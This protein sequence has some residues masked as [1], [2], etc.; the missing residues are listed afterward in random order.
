MKNISDHDH[1]MHRG[2]HENMYIHP[3][4]R[5]KGEMKGHQAEEVATG[6]KGEHALGD[7]NKINSLIGEPHGADVAGHKGK[8]HW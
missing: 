7:S 4:N 3:H 5:M 2:P 6:G 1:P 8:M